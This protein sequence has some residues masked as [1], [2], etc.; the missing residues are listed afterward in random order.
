MLPS[1]KYNAAALLHKRIAQ[2]QGELACICDSK[3]NQ[4]LKAAEKTPG[5]FVAGFVD[6]GNV[7]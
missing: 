6:R 7:W 3:W 1:T 5:R 4:G 2:K